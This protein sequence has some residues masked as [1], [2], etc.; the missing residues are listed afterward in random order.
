M[1]GIVTE[2]GGAVTRHAVGDRVGVGCM[3][4]SCRE[5]ANCRKGYEQYCL[6]GN[7]L[8][9][10]SIDRDGILAIVGA[11]PEYSL[12]RSSL[13]RN[14]RAFSGSLIGGLPVTQEMLDFCAAHGVGAEI[15]TVGAKQIN[16][17]YERVLASDV[18]YRFVIDNATFS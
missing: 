18:R 11:T 7:I 17:A 9:Y 12:H 1:T 13:V 4:N 2:I 15:E 16:E 8:T 3:V 14:Q 6:N 10:G 5:C